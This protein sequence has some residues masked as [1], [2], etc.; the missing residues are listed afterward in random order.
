MPSRICT[1]PDATSANSRSPLAARDAPGQHPHPH[2]AAGQ[3]PL[4]R[5]GVLLH[6]QFGRRHQSRL[7]SVGHG[8][9]HG[10]NRHHRLAA[11]HVS[12]KQPIGRLRASQIGHDLRQHLVLAGRQLERKQPAN[13][14]VDLGRSR[15]RDGVARLDRFGPPHGQGQ[16][17]HQQ[18]LIDKP[19]PGTLDV[20]HGQ[21]KV[22]VLDRPAD[23]GQVVGLPQRGAKHVVDPAGTNV[24]RRTD[25]LAHV[26]LPQSLGQRIDRQ[27][28]ARGQFGLFEILDRRMGHLPAVAKIFRLAGDKHPL[29]DAKPLG[30]KRLIEPQA[31]AKTAN[32][33]G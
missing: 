1:S 31:L 13:P 20:G 32:P 2:Q 4:E 11:P 10:V 27:Q 16:L 19:M 26:P 15:Q 24:E 22:D 29:A 9:Q 30:Q 21:R 33:A 28:P 3:Q 23:L 14:G 6:D 17:H 8:H 7:R 25:Q 18:L 12:L 5:P